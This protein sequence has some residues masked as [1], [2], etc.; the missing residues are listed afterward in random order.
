MKQTLITILRDHRTGQTD[1]RIATEKIASLLAVE[2]SA[3]LTKVENTV[4][5][6]IGPASG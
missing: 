5:T 3:Y 1:F 6:P 4:Q 2:T